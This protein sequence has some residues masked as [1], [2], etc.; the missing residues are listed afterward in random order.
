MPRRLGVLAALMC[1]VGLLA[2]GDR[3]RRRAD[4]ANRPR[5]LSSRSRSSPVLRSSWPPP[6]PWSKT[7]SPSSG[8]PTASSGSSRW[9]TIRWAPTAKANPAASSGSWKTAT[10]TADTTSRR[11]FSTGSAFPPASCPGARACW[12]PALRI[13]SMPRTATATARPTIARCSSPALA[14]GNQQHRL[15]GFELGLDGWVYGANGDSDGRVRSLKTGKIDPDQRPRFP[16]P[17]RH[18]RVRGRERPDPVWPAPRRLGPLVR[19][20]QPQL[21]L[22]LRAGQSRPAA[23]PMLRPARPAADA[24]ARH[25]ALPDQPHARPV[26]RRRRGQ[27]RHVGQQPD[28][29]SRRPLRARGS[30]Q[31][32]LSASRCTTWCI[33]SCSSPRA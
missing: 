26:Q 14:E 32:S 9:A 28:A 2:A 13:S 3:S 31:A 19:Q 24:R 18:R 16:V 25:A 20:Q 22:A 17:A 4:R 23:Q 29:L 6:S 11:P 33:G 5:N 8:G 15:N 12:S 30:P 1:R 7:R 10:A 27:P 21:G